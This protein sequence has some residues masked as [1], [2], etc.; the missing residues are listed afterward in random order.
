MRRI[1]EVQI[2]E[3]THAPSPEASS[4]SD[5][6]SSTGSTQELGTEMSLSNPPDM[7]IDRG[8][9]AKSEK[10][11]SSP[12]FTKFGDIDGYALTKM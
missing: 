3:G 10:N 1:R 12:I 4:E 11:K 2:P 5:T 8:C 6:A 9:N 7:N